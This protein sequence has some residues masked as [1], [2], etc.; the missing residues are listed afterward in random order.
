MEHLSSTQPDKLAVQK[1]RLVRTE[2]NSRNRAEVLVDI[3][4]AMDRTD[5]DIPGVP[6]VAEYKR[7][8]VTYLAKDLEWGLEDLS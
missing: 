3:I 8:I 6:T 7:S 4:S 2:F 5:E 1:G